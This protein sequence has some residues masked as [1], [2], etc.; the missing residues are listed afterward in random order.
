MYSRPRNGRVDKTGR[1]RGLPESAGVPGTSESIYL[2]DDTMY[3]SDLNGEQEAQAN[4]L[5][6]QIL[7]PVG[8]IKDLKGSG[9]KDVESLAAR[10]QVPVPAMRVRLGIPSV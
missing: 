4:K 2:T 7:M 10:L 8:L 3:R 6:T 9:I 1:R 5:A